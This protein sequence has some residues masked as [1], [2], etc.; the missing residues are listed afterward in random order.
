MVSLMC[1]S[2]RRPSMSVIRKANSMAALGPVSTNGDQVADVS[3]VPFQ[4]DQQTPLSDKA[5]ISD[6]LAFG[7][8]LRI[9]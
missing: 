7:H 9:S 4:G 2:G 3:A 5:D 1:Y 8:L 6:L